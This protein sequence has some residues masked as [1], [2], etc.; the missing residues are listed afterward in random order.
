MDES[1]FAGLIRR[2]GDSK[3][4]SRAHELYSR[5]QRS[6]ERHSTYLANLCAHMYGKCGSAKDARRV[7]DEIQ[8]P[9]VFSWTILMQAYAANG[10]LEQVEN[11]FHTMPERDTAAW[12]TMIKAYASRG[13][14]REARRIFDLMPHKNVI[15]WTAMLTAHANRG[16][17]EQAQELFDKMPHKNTVTWNA[18]LTGA[19]AR[20]GH[21]D[22]AKIL[23]A[24]LP[25]S[26]KNVVSWNAMLQAYADNRELDGAEHIFWAM[27]EHNV[28][29]WTAMVTAN[30]KC[31]RLEQADSVFGAM[32]ERSL[33]SW[34]AMME[35]YSDSAGQGPKTLEL[36]RE[37]ELVGLEP[38]DLSFMSLL[39][40]CSHGGLSEQGL[41]Y[42]GR[43]KASSA[44]EG[45]SLS[46][47]REHYCCIVDML[48]R[49]GRLRDAEE[50][51]E[52]MPF[53]PGVVEWGSLLGACKTYSDVDRAS[54]AVENI[55]ELNP[56]N[57][58]ANSALTLLSNVYAAA[59]RI[60]EAEAVQTRL[61]SRTRVRS[62]GNS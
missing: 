47:S 18:L 42:F 16:E 8:E 41:S 54:R 59:G 4:L 1:S 11:A 43:L 9:N 52:S 40:A 49:S 46:P 7:F 44:V 23:F 21:L 48:G 5:L 10:H 22:E 26:D 27:P 2:C 58:A 12:N 51:V 20:H 17:M 28:V 45:S 39:N 32:P 30:A 3:D 6:R 61:R 24:T 15:S 60:R 29:S 57:R 53:E 35:S 62:D 13:R 56:G 55:V 25:E 37:L 14:I 36:F 19:Y 33:V 34:N 50:L 31:G 38:N